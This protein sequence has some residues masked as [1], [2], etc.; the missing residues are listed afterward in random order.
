MKKVRNLTQ[1]SIL[2]N[3]LIVALPVLLTTISQMAYNLTDMFWIGKVDEI[4]MIEADAITAVGTVSYLVWLSFGFILVSKIGT[5]VKISHAVGRNKP[6]DID[7]Y[8][9]N[10]IL[11]QLFLGVFMSGI[12]L[13]FKE[14]FLGIFNLENQNILDYALMYAPIIGGFIFIQFLVNGFT[15]INE[16]LGQ[17]KINLKILFVGFLLNII[18]DPI[19]ILVFKL[20]IRGAAIAT[21]ISQFVTLIILI[22]VYKRHNPNIEV[23]KF[24]NINFNAIKDIVRVGLPTGIHSILFTCISIYIGVRIVSFGETILG[25]Q[26]IGAQI[27]QL[28][29][30]IGGGFQTAITVFVGQNIGAKKYS[31]VRKG[32]RVISS[33]L[34]PYSLAVTAL[35]FFFSEQLIGVFIDD[36]NTIAYGSNYLRIISLS[37]IFMMFEAIGTGTF[38]GLG[39]SFIP[40]ANGIVGNLLRVPLAIILSLTLLE[41]GIWWA[42]NISSIFK[43]TI[44]LIG[45]I[46]LFTRLEKIKLKNLEESNEEGAYV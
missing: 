25:A 32:V 28:T 4:G 12:I 33:L 26:R 6:E 7:V 34:I 42:I 8:A 18:L 38:Y 27:E 23:F 43:G 19:F 11:M 39:K 16:G 20:G 35:L 31:R 14:E 45:V 41:S 13:I 15:G 46:L 5:S 22:I 9:S 30:M 3:L 17:T 1:G 21:V 2:K 29:W 40:S 10:G 36:P 44:M 37:Q 24:K